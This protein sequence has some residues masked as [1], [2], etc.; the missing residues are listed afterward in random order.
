MKHL[1]ELFEERNRTDPGSMEEER[2]AEKILEA[3]FPD[4]NRDAEEQRRRR[5][6]LQPTCVSR[7]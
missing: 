7:G 1:K 4:S 3:I 2:A 5:S 6:I